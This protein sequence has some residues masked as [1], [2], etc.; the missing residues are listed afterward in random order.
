MV[1]PTVPRRSPLPSGPGHAVWPDRWEA[2]SSPPLS[3]AG[4]MGT[5]LA[6]LGHAARTGRA[7]L[8]TYAWERPT[9][10]FGRN[11]PV[12]GTWDVDAMRA[13]GCDVVRRPTG[14]RA[15]LHEHEVTWS[16]TL[17]L[18]PRVPW[19]RMY[20][21]VNRRL[22]HALRALGVPAMLHDARGTRAPVP[23][24]SHCFAA[25]S[26]GELVVAHGKVAGSAVWRADGGYLQHG[27]ILLRDT[28]ARLDAFRFGGGETISPVMGHEAGGGVAPWLSSADERAMAALVIAAL[29]DAWGIADDARA[30]D[31]RAREI[32][33]I[34]PRHSAAL[35]SDDA[36]LAARAQFD[37][38]A[39]L[40]RR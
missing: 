34:P 32:T 1:V 5:D 24:G 9:V 29:H 40:W 28:Q 17:P 12:R 3:G 19:R 35:P 10:S 33:D 16:V 4:N 14:G 20:D 21:A 37:D 22:L 2:L 6:L 13:A 25:P 8:R 15:L 39:W 30:A 7:V 31:G 18:D 38:A 11:E 23:D 36:V 27:S 26:A